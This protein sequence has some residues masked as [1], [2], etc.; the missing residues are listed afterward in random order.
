MFWKST[1]WAKEGDKRQWTA[2]AESKTAFVQDSSDYS[3]SLY[4]KAEHGCTM[5]EQA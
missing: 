3:A 2:E 4:T 5:H 1:E